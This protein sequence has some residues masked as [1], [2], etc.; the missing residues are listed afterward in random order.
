MSSFAGL[1][2]VYGVGQWLPKI[3][4]DLGY[5]T[6]DSLL[7]SA[8]LNVGGF[9]GMF[10]AG[11]LSDAVGPRRIVIVWFALTAVFVHLL[12]AGLSVDLL[13]VVAFFAGL[14]L[15]SGQTMVYATV[16]T[17]HTEAERATALGLGRGHGPLR[18]GLRTLARRCAAVRG[19]RPPR[20]IRPWRSR[21]RRRRAGRAR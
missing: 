20:R 8:V 14:L 10:V 16:G 3:M 4:G 6:G 15:F 21:S 7:F 12:G 11:R 17:H 19:P 1:M 2:L 13:Y 9:V 5:E 18:R